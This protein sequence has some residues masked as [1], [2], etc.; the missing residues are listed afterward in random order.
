MG[1]LNPGVGCIWRRWTAGT[2][3][4]KAD[5]EL[6][7]LGGR[8]VGDLR[9]SAC[10]AE[11]RS[12]RYGLVWGIGYPVLTGPICTAGCA[13]WLLRDWARRNL[14]TLETGKEL[15]ECLQF[16]HS[17]AESL[18]S[19]GERTENSGVERA[20]GGVGL[21]GSGPPG[22]CFLTLLETTWA[23]MVCSLAFKFSLTSI[24]SSVKWGSQQPYDFSQDCVRIKSFGKYILLSLNLAINIIFVFQWNPILFKHLWGWPG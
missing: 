10:G 23:H 9:V 7:G 11:L 18:N 24:T 16:L 2:G 21:P 5:I 8:I 4:L 20:A 1:A 15:K 12:C 6:Q 3:Q 14:P 13:Y 19:T 22:A 17:G